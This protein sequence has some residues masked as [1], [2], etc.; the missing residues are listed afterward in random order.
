[1]SER[2][3]MNLAEAADF[4]RLSRSTMHQRHDIPRHR[5][6]GSREYRYLRSELL[7]WLKGERPTVR[8]TDPV[9]WTEQTEQPNMD[10]STQRV[11]HRNARY[12]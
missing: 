5:V 6:P 12:W 4:L 7:A 2:E 9:S 1:M 8:M 10:I 3:V 11:Y